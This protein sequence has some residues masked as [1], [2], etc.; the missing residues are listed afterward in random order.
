MALAK[1]ETDVESIE[2]MNAF[3]VKFW[4]IYNPVLCKTIVM[5]VDQVLSSQIFGRK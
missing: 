3:L 1:L 2:W 5:T 4:P